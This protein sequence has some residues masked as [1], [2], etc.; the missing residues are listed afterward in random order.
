MNGEPGLVVVRGADPEIALDG[1]LDEDQRA[2]LLAIANRCSMP[3]ENVVIRWD[4]GRPIAEHCFRSRTRC[5]PPD[6]AAS[7]PQ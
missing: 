1:S 7:V 3:Q 4:S 6:R 2:R 5:R